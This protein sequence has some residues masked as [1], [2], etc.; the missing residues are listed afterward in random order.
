[1]PIH[2]KLLHIGS[3]GFQ[4]FH[5]ING[6]FET[7]HYASGWNINYILRAMCRLFIIIIIIIIIIKQTVGDVTYVSQK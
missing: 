5:V 2:E 4:A 7:G 3:C 6:A 1:M